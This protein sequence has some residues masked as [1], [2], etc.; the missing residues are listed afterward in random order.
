MLN[1]REQ[2]FMD[3]EELHKILENHDFYYVYSEDGKIYDKGKASQ[4]KID[5][6]IEKIGSEGRKLYQQFLLMQ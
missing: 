4:D 2:K 5:A 3:I 6:L 1:K